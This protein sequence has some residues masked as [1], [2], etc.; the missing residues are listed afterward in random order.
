MVFMGCHSA[1]FVNEKGAEKVRA[2]ILKY[3]IKHPVINDDKMIKLIM[4]LIILKIPHQFT[5]EILL[6]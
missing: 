3:E 5:N 6:G 4:K 1:K 2:A